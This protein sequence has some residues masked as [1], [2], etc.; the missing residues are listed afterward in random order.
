MH[1]LV[2]VAKILTEVINVAVVAP[3][4]RLIQDMPDD[5]RNQVYDFARY[6]LDKRIREEQ[7]SWSLF[8]LREA[9]QQLE[10]ESLYTKTDLKERWQ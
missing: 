2:L 6:L 5:L 10:P 3:L 7:L 9:G 4:E 1:H 8:S